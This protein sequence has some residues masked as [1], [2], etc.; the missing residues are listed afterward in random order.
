MRI[1]PNDFIGEGFL[2]FDVLFAWKDSPVAGRIS[3][4]FVLDE[5]RDHYGRKYIS[6]K[7]KMFSC[8]V[9]GLYSSSV[10]AG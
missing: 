10:S 1:F 3:V 5:K 7:K 4:L 9:R 6:L 2:H 8:V